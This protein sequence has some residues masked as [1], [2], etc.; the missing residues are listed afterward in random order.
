MK[1]STQHAFNVPNMLCY[2]R[3][4]L[5]PFFSYF[6]LADPKNIKYSYI[7][8]GLIL[9]SGLTDMLDG[10][11]ARRFNKVTEWGKVIDPVADK[12][13]QFAVAVCLSITIRGMVL[14]VLVVF[15]KEIFMGICCLVFLR[16]DRKLDGAMWFG[17]VAT[18]VFYVLI[19]AL[20]V[21]PGLSMQ[22]KFIF[23]LITT[24]FM[25]LSLA[26]YIREFYRMS[27]FY[28]KNKIEQ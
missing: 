11:I 22:V 20:L 5:I 16:K 6:L 4:L 21:F 9:I 1:I 14:L 12:L 13:T 7:A 25:L 23:V 27:G 26:L 15:V 24:G 2:I 10:F 28:K 8:A 3:I 19:F 18:A 17:K